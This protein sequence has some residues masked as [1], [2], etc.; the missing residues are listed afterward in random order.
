MQGRIQRT[1][2]HETGRPYGREE[3]SRE[4]MEIL[5][6]KLAILYARIDLDPDGKQ[7]EAQTTTVVT[8]SAR[9]ARRY[10][11]CIDAGLTMPDTTWANLPDGVGQLAKQEKISTQAF[12][13]SVKA[14]IATLSR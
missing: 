9:N 3:P 13:K 5:Q 8:A 10:Q 12:S 14:H 1:R 6:A 4:E 2:R 7:A 11:M